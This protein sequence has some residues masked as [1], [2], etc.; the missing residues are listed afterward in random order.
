MA[1]MVVAP[2]ANRFERNTMASSFSW[3]Q[4]STRRKSTGFSPSV[5]RNAHFLLHLVDGLLLHPRHEV[6]FLLRQFPKPLVIDVATVD[7]QDGAR[8][9]PQRARHLDLAGLALG[10]HRER[11]QVAIMVQQ[12][13]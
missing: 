5:L 7:G 3:S 9:E 2:K 12:Q 6:H 8:R 13:V 11:R 4:I 1:A 10:H